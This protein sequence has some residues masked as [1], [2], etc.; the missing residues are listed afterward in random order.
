MAARPDGID[1]K[2]NATSKFQHVMLKKA[3]IASRALCP[4]GTARLC[5]PARSTAKSTADPR[6][7]QSERKIQG[8]TSD[9]ATFMAVQLKPHAS[10]RPASIHHSLRGRWSGW[11][12]LIASPVPASEQRAPMRRIFLPHPPVEREWIGK[13]PGIVGKILKHAYLCVTSQTASM[14]SPI[15]AAESR[16]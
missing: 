8:A 12:S 10:V 6:P 9:N 15:P 4:F 13:H 3:S 2:P 1:S 5:P 7:R 11:R 14:A 16:L